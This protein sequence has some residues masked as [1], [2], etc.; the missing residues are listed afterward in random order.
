MQQVPHEGAEIVQYPVEILD[1]EKCRDFAENLHED[2]EELLLCFNI[3]NCAV[4]DSGLPV[5]CNGKH[6]WENMKSFLN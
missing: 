3:S 2:A 5:F 1:F 4:N 6:E